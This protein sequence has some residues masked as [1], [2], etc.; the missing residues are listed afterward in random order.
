MG[1][2]YHNLTLRGARQKDVVELLRVIDREAIVSKTIDNFVVVFDREYAAGGVI[3]RRLMDPDGFGYE[4]EKTE[5]QPLVATL[6]RELACVGFG[7]EVHDDDYFYYELFGCG[8]NID[9]YVSKAE[10]FQLSRYALPETC[11]DASLLCELLGATDSEHQIHALLH[12]GA[13][14]YVFAHDFHNDLVRALGL[15]IISGSWRYEIAKGWIDFPEQHHNE[16][17]FVRVFS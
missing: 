15:P 12:G 17:G 10:R 4:P 11:G 7:T 3:D 6:T 5:W 8:E 1:M 16:F 9:T 14:D 2:F 13:V